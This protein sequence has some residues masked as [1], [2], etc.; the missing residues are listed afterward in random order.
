MGEGKLVE[1]L[2]QCGAHIGLD[3]RGGAEPY[4]RARRGAFPGEPNPGGTDP[5]DAHRSITHPQFRGLAVQNGM[6]LR[7]GGLERQAVAQAGG[8]GQDDEPEPQD[9]ED[10]AAGLYEGVVQR[11][12]GQFVGQVPAPGCGGLAGSHPDDVDQKS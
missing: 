3:V 2:Q 12:G 10:G 8:E 6:R 11:A 1:F 4:V 7:G 5:G 9:G